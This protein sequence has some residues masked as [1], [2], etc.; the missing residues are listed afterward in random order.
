M[1]IG[2]VTLFPEMFRAVTEY[3]VT[4]RATTRGQLQVMTWSPRDFADDRHRTVD[5]R[6][7]GGGPGML[8]KVEPLRRAIDAARTG[9]VPWVVCL[10]PQGRK[11]DHAKVVELSQRP[12]LLLLA[13]RYEGF[14]ERLIDAEADE[15]ISIGDFVLS[16]GELAAMALIDAVTRLL[17]G[18]LGD[19]ASAAG[20]SFVD[21]L[22]DY[23]QYTRPQEVNGV[24]VPDVLLSGNHAEIRRWRFQQAL[25][26]TWLR[27]PDLLA[28]RVLSDEERRLLADFMAS[29][30]MATPGTGFP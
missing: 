14:D 16:G 8:M 17:P 21:G 10:S 26:R 12:Q 7:F 25:A 30:E 22:L 5:D 23:P 11:L 20:E 15:E 27:R 6:P 24:R 9:R 3:G 13:G 18:V 28:Q 29:L 4:G 19:D 1:W 2:V